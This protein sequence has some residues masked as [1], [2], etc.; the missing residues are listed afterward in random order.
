M[1]SSCASCCDLEGID[2]GRGAA[3]SSRSTSCSMSLSPSP[4]MS[5]ARRLAKCR[6]ASW[7]WAR[8]VKAAGAAGHRLA[9]GAQHARVAHRAGARQ[10]HRLRRPAAGA[11]PSTP[12]HLGYDVAGAAH[13]HRVPDAHV[14]ALHLVDV[15]QRDV[16]HGDAA[17]EHRLQARHRG[18]RPGAPDLELDAADHAS[19]ASSAGNLCAIAQRGARDTKP[20]RSWS[21]RDVHLV[22]HAVDLV[23]QAR[24]PRAERAVVLEAALRRRAPRA[25]PARPAGPSARS[26][27]QQLALAGRLRCRPRARPGRRR[28]RQRPRGGDARVELAQAPGGGIARIDEDLLALLARLRVHARKA[29]ETA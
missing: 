13:D 25:P 20:R 22:D 15:V 1:R 24:A 10:L 28:S 14:L 29:R 18:Q 21:A 27:S 3:R 12:H 17:D 7:R 16:A 23:R 2:V 5:S 19:S 11:R 8:Q 6:S 9:F 4:S 26:R